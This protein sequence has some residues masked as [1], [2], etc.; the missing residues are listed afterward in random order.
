MSNPRG[1]PKGYK[2]SIES[3]AKISVTKTGQPHS[4]AT[5]AKIAA[6]VVE[7]FDN[8]PTPSMLAKDKRLMCMG[9]PQVFKALNMMNF[10]HANPEFRQ[11]MSVRMK[12][13][14]ATKNM[15]A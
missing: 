10:W 5:K 2:M 15:V 13:W 12:E 3:K 14:H 6:S 8:N 11:L 1:R 4:A 9:K 7:Y